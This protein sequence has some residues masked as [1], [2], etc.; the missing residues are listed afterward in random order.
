M[1]PTLLLRHRLKLCAISY[2]RLLRGT[3][4]NTSFLTMSVPIRQGENL[5]R[6]DLMSLGLRAFFMIDLPASRALH[7]ANLI[8]AIHA[9]VDGL[10]Y[11]NGSP[12]VSQL[13]SPRCRLEAAS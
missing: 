7:H 13:E 10:I 1:E 12:A 4:L 8:F 5:I 3:L 2:N 6:L 11:A 9:R